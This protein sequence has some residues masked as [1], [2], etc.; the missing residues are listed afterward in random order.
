MESDPAEPTDANLPFVLPGGPFSSDKPELSYAALI[1]RAIL[2]SPQHKL[3]LKD[4]YDYISIVYP[5]Y[6]REG[7]SHSQ[8]WMNA[9]RQNLT[10]T[11]QFFKEV[12]PDGTSKGSLWCIS[13]HDLPC[14]E[15]GGYNKHALSSSA[16][17]NS[18]N[19]KRKRKREDDL[20]KA[21]AKRS[22][23]T[24]PSNPNF[25]NPY[26]FPYG[27][28][29][30]QMQYPIAPGQ[31]PPYYFD[32][33]GMMI[34]SADLIF[35]PL[36][37]S[38]PSAHLVNGSQSQPMSEQ[39]LQ[40]DVNM[41]FPPLPPYSQTRQAREAIM[42]DA[43]AASDPSQS[44]HHQQVE[45][46]ER[47]SSSSSPGIA[48]LSSSTSSIPS[49]P[50]LTPNNSS[51]SPVCGDDEVFELLYPESNDVA[52]QDECSPSADELHAVHPSEILSSRVDKGK[53]RAI[54][55]TVSSLRL[56]RLTSH[57]ELLC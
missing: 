54:G 7:H 43:A 55:T 31:Q 40:D 53:G 9:I 16:S 32:Q 10:N 36:P 5:F 51:S 8:K 52:I 29:N 44:V 22:H 28:A 15:G 14:F 47:A 2:A 49:V 42:R 30:Q 19:D 21:E 20:Q 46:Y 50:A 11:P 57:A 18:K 41:L 39:H 23:L 33:G 56:L 38:H 1:G 37:P 35:P 17:A 4:I 13:D 45:H 3:R 48:P 24:A 12:H 34:Q 25:P 27:F 6:K 26:H